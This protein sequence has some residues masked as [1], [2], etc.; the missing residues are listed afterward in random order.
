MVKNRSVYLTW[1]WNGTGLWQTDRITTAITHYKS[2]PENMEI[3]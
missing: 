1:S 2:V 3:V